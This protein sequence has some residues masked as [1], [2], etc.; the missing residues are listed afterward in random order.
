MGKEGVTII[1]ESTGKK[2]TER[3]IK[4]AIHPAFFKD[5]FLGHD[6]AFG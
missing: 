3:E 2:K 1:W 6:D 5:L 4:E